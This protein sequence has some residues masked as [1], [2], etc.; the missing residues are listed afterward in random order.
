M[1]KKSNETAVLDGKRANATE[2]MDHNKFKMRP[3]EVVNMIREY[4]LATMGDWMQNNADVYAKTGYFYIRLPYR[5][6]INRV[7][8]DEWRAMFRRGVF[9]R[10][11]HLGLALRAMCGEELTGD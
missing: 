8:D 9:L 4:I 7:A 1:Q 2:L 5:R 6:P 3:R 11:H 10:R